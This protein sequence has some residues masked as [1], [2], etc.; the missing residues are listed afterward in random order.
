LRPHRLRFSGIGAYPGE[1]EIDFDD[2]NHKGLYLIVGP[3]GAGKTTLLDAITYALYG[4]VAQDRENAIVS[5]HAHAQPPVIEFEFSQGDRRYIAHREPAPPGKTAVP[6]KQWIRVF[7]HVGDE[8]SSDTGARQVTGICSEVVGLSADEFMQ[9]ILLPQG[10]FQQFLMAKGSD[11]QKLLKT[12]FGTWTYQ[13]IAE[14]LVAVAKKL[15][16]DVADDVEE[17][18]RKWA[19]IDSALGTLPDVDPFDDVPDPRDYLAAT[20]EF[21]AR[22]SAHLDEAESK[23]RSQQTKIGAAHK[24]AAKE[25]ARFDTAQTLK[26]LQVEH[27]AGSRATASARTRTESH[28]RAVPVVSAADVCN[29]A[30][31]LADAKTRTVVGLRTRLARET[32]KMKV[33]AAVTKTWTDSLSTANPS[34]L[35]TEFGKMLTCLNDAAEKYAR[36]DEVADLVKD[37]ATEAKESVKTIAGLQREITAAEALARKTAI[38]VATA[39][40]KVKGLRAAEKALD[41]LRELL[42]KADVDGAS[43]ELTRTTGILSRAQTAFD[44][45]EAALRAARDQRTKQLAGVLAAELS[46]GDEC[47]VCGST[48]HPRKAR[49]NAAPKSD[50]DSLES[51]RTTAQRALTNAERDVK[52]AQKALELAQKHHQGLPTPAQQAKIEKTYEDLA[53]IGEQI[54]DLAE[55]A[56]DAATAVRDLKESLAEKRAEASR[57]STEAKTLE[58]E[59]ATLAKAVEAVGTAKTVEASLVTCDVLKELLEELDE[60]VNDL[61]EVKGK[62]TASVTAFEKALKASPFADEKAAR[63]A[64]LDDDTLDELDAAVEA[65]DERAVK[66]G[67]LEA[68]VGTDPLPKTRPDVD[69]LAEQLEAADTATAEA[70]RIAGTIRTALVQI[71][72][73]R[74]DIDRIGPAIEEKQRQAT[75]AMSIATVFDKGA[76]GVDGQLSLEVWVQ[77]TLFE[78]VCLV[79]NEQLRSLSSNRYSLTLEQEEGGVRKKRGSGLDIYVLD[80]HT[81]KTRPVQT[82]SGGEQFVASLALALALAEVVQRHA[83][84]IELPCLF[85]DE[86]FGGLDL[87]SLDIAIE[88]LAKIQ[89][90]GRTVGIITHVEAMQQQLPIGIRVNKT[91]R[92]SWLE[93][94]AS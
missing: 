2:L 64:T 17:V 19:V 45:A 91:D 81:G 65:H 7:D 90:A 89:A 68:S 36:L 55:K 29:E 26:T 47:P 59:R 84:G 12:I 80:S 87:E 23:A 31:S 76:G 11:K 21:I 4:R 83:G 88:V 63:A 78:E 85:I 42:E 25:A 35:S 8:I 22:H 62:V 40:D 70:S 10:K 67:R 86:G 51:T 53:E 73:A 24:M 61:T 93:V 71:T 48:D 1:V 50:I 38:N 39:R 75:D 94:L 9:V 20:V 52:E 46:P 79:A 30:M 54:D 56:D 5:A 60:S 44:R 33:S 43:A 49:T 34:A 72:S 13:R 77:R 69:A 58:K 74:A 66:I 37:N 27:S 41:D 92:G 3:T 14:R 16:Q 32:A 57:I 82:M 15:E 18:N 28:R 6:N